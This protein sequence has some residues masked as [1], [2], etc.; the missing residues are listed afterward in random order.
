MLNKKRM[1]ESCRIFNCHISQ[2]I[3]IGS[4]KPS[5]SPNFPNNYQFYEIIFSGLKE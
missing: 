1:V 4:G 5:D 3:I 2:I